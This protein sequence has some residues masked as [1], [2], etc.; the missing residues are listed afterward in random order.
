MRKILFALLMVAIVAFGGLRPASAQSSMSALVNVPFDFIVGGRV[1]PAG[2]YEISA[3]VKDPTLLTVSSTGDKRVSVF[4]ATNWATGL[5]P[6]DPNVR[7]AFKNVHG[8]MFLW[9]IAMP[10][11][12]GREIVVTRA[13]AVRTLAKLNLLPTDVG[14]DGVK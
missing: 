2:T 13:E 8:H 5:V 6:N 7:V 11:G 4:A 9:Q 12:N 1:L 3:A 14:G 10:G